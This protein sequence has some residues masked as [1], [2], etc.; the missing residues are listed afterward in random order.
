[1]KSPEAIDDIYSSLHDHPMSNAF[2]SRLAYLILK[3]APEETDISKSVVDFFERKHLNVEAIDT[4]KYAINSERS[5]TDFSLPG[6]I[7][8]LAWCAM[9]DAGEFTDYDF[10]FYFCWAKGLGLTEDVVVSLYS[11]ALQF[12]R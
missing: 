5:E 9:N 7:N 12:N 4:L 10:D 2:A 11:Q 3:A 6:I 1:M 8:Q